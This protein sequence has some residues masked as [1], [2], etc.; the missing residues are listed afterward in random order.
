MCVT[1]EV[2]GMQ[3]IKGTDRLDKLRRQYADG[4]DQNLP[5][6]KKDVTWV[7]RLQCVQ[8]A[9]AGQLETL[10]KKS[11]NMRVALITFNGDVCIVG[12]GVQESVTVAGGKLNN[13]DTCWMI[14]A[15]Y[16]LNT[17]ISKSAKDLTERIFSLEEGGPTALGPA[18][19][20]GVGMASRCPGSRVVMCTDGMANVGVGA[21][22]GLTTDAE[23][24]AAEKFYDELG[25]RASKH[26]VS[27]SVVSI[28][29]SDCRME[30]LGAVADASKGSVEMVR[31]GVFFVHTH[32]CVCVC[33]CA[34]RGREY[35]RV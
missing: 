9:I 10:Q 11:P 6:Q 3:K 2:S 8:A 35:V 7:S 28:K 32:V 14:G 18:L 19:M 22:E 23:K 20:A 13:A 21:L 33:V 16:P 29:G 15:D 30:N 12:D 34:E 5:D 17:P 25:E 4:F 26:G 24:Q 31:S 27:V 1:T